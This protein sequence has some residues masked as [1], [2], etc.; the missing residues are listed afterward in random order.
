MN[1]RYLEINYYQ[2]PKYHQLIAGDAFIFHKVTEENR[3]ISVLSDG[4]GSGIKASVL[5]TLTSSMAKNLAAQKVEVTQIAE[6]IMK[7]LPVCK[8]RRISYSTFTIVDI[9]ESHHVSVIEY[10]NPRFLFVR[11]NKIIDDGSVITHKILGEYKNDYLNLYSFK[12]S[13]NDRI[14]YFSDGVTQSGM[15]TPNHPFGWT[16]EKVITFVENQILENS[17]ISAADLSKNIVLRSKTNDHFKCKD[18][19]TCGVIYSRL[20]RRTL[21]VTGPPFDKSKD[22][23]MARAVAL[24]DGKKIICGGTTA[25]II[26]RELD[27]EVKVNISNLDP[28]VPPDSAMA[29]VDLITEG[30]ITMVH[31]RSLLQEGKSSNKNSNAAVKV[32]NHLLNSD[33][34]E[35]IVGTKINEVHQDPN[36]PG[37]LAI[38]KT[39]IRDIIKILEDQYL[40]RVNVRFI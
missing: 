31:V 37:D 11:S 9:E 21:V 22:S 2:E 18:D 33:I 30:I 13:K 34:I 1:N 5:A 14:I 15:G 24:F 4:L 3:I 10:G 40:K 36:I 29:G 6:I 16:R 38:R 32:V 25:K 12:L 23:E 20:P 7:T 28:N 27:L 17:S 35:F 39:I 8:V 19:T 26:S